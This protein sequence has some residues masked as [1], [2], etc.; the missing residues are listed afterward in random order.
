MCF[1]SSSLVYRLRRASLVIVVWGVVF[2]HMRPGIAQDL[3]PARLPPEV[4][5]YCPAY[6]DSALYRPRANVIHVDFEDD[7]V[8]IIKSAPPGSEVLLA[9]GTYEFKDHQ[10]EV[11]DD[12][13]VRSA[14]GNRDRV[15]IRGVGY[16]RDSQ[17]LVIA[18]D[19]VTIADVTVTAMRDHG[20]YVKP[21]LGGGLAPLVY[22]VHVFDIG[23]QHIKSN[24]GSR[25]G[26][27]ACSSIGYTERGAKGDYNGAIDLHGAI[28]WTIRDNLIYNINGDGS[29]CNVN[30]DCGRY[31]SSP[32]I[33]VWSNSRDTLVERNTIRESYRNIAFGLGRGHS[34]GVIRNNF[35]TR[36]IAGDAGI[37]LQ[38]VQNVIV[39]NNT[40]LLGDRYRGAV[41]YRASSSVVVRSNRLTSEPWD[42][43]NNTDVGL[44]D[45]TVVPAPEL[46]K[47]PAPGCRRR[48]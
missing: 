23:T 22:N 15:I 47:Q 27:I 10:I 29:G 41:E 8:Y 42:R 16:R 31:I 7:W 40:V 14:S 34:G 24:T 5:Q 19:R 2:V 9:D 1:K 18:G 33:L 32:A 48:G 17:G 25:N 4:P 12:V 30:R 36:S 37:E 3:M 21:E 13:T 45:N 35:I 26:I 20:I 39:E 6:T 44:S 11:G 43:G 28:A 46:R 38:D